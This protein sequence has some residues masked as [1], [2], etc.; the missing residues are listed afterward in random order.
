MPPPLTCPPP[1]PLIPRVQVRV[2]LDTNLTMI[3][4]R[5][6]E[7]LNGTRWYRDPD[8]A[9]PLN[10]ITRFPHAVLEV[11]HTPPYQRPYYPPGPGPGP[12]SARGLCPGPTRVPHP[13]PS[14]P[15]PPSPSCAFTG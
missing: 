9:V 13:V 6:K 11:M 2:S 15:R 7:T 4:E 12:S 8:T 10:E 1:P 14:S 5:T 3:N